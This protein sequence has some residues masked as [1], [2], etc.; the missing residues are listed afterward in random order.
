MPTLIVRL[1]VVLGLSVLFGVGCSSMPRSSGDLD[2]RSGCSLVV[3]ERTQVGTQV[4]MDVHVSGC[5]DQNGNL[6]ERTPAVDR[7]AHAIWQS[8]ELPV[9]A[10][11]VSVSAP[12]AS[13]EGTLTT[14][15]R[16]E[17]TERFGRGPS[18]VVWPVRDW[19]NETIWVVLPLAYLAVGMA[20][21][22]LVRGIR[23]AGLVVV[24]LRR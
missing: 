2:Q 15:A 4:V 1:L 19:P 8:L 23:R 11:R 10:V 13:A 16:D 20:M 17:L 22:L 6:L 12:G 18:G 9:D 3:A 5:R 24:L 7:V 21:L 14:I